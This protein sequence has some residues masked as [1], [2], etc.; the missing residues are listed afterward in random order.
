M[1]VVLVFFALLSTTAFGFT[2]PNT[3]SIP[4]LS[5]FGSRDI[6]NDS[7]NRIHS[8]SSVVLNAARVDGI[9]FDRT[10]QILSLLKESIVLNPSTN[11]PC[12]ALDG[13]ESLVD[14]LIEQSKLNRDGENDA[15]KPQPNLLN[16]SNFLSSFNN[17]NPLNSKK[18]SKLL[19]II[20]PQYGDFDSFEYAEFLSCIQPLLSQNGIALRIIGIGDACSAAKFCSFTGLDLN[21]VR[22]ITDGTLHEALDVSS[23]PDWGVGLIPKSICD[24]F[25]EIV[26]GNSMDSEQNAEDETM[27]KEITR[28]WLNYMAMCAGIAAPDT[29]PEIL[30]GYI[31]DKT[32]PERLNPNDIVTV[33]SMNGNEENAIIEPFIQI[34]GTTDVKLGPFQYQNSWK[35]EL[36]YQRPVELAT[37]R[38]K[39]MVEV[40]SNF[41]E[42]VPDQRFLHLRGGT[43]LFGL[44]GNGE[45]DNTLLYEYMDTGVLAYSKTMPRPLSFLEKY[46]G[47]EALNPQ[48][49]GDSS[50]R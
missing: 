22:V 42:Y 40:L 18:Y 10:N 37:V 1:L 31:G 30:R 36:G 4:S 19:L 2:L 3:S 16:V 14:Q 48:G 41:G 23:G 8:R 39:Y 5:D 7:A 32:A 34:T 50:K 15:D 43:L 24:W 47:K 44:D 9:S 27:S 21:N 6:K 11:Q 38:L 33:P 13:L 29:L 17:N 20:M 46:I 28:S 25:A 45:D 26:T 12:S 49:L 35:D